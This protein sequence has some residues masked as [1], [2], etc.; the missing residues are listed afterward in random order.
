MEPSPGVVALLAAASGSP[1]ANFDLKGSWRNSVHRTAASPASVT[2]A[3]AP[4]A[5]LNVLFRIS[6]PQGVEMRASAWPPKR[7]TS[8]LQA[9]RHFIPARYAPPRRL[10]R[11]TE[12]L[13]EMEPKL[14]RLF[15]AAL[16]ASRMPFSAMVSRASAAPYFRFIA[17]PRLVS[18]G[19]QWY[20]P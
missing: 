9:K 19:P 10:P 1:P 15:P 16:A 17:I 6:P 18:K 11:A 12:P 5:I 2:N 14:L 20:Q 3:V 7:R 4:T 13:R 8:R